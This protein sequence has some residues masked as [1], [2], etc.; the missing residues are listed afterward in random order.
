MN[1]GTAIRPAV[2]AGFVAQVAFSVWLMTNVRAEEAEL[3]PRTLPTGSPPAAPIGWVQTDL[4]VA[5]LPPADWRQIGE[6]L[7][8][9]Y[10][11]IALNTLEKWDH[12][13]PRSNDYPAHVVKNADAYLRRFV[14]TVHE[15]GAKAIFY[16]GPVQSPLVADIREKHED[17]LRVNEDGSKAKDYVNFRNPQFVNWLCEQLAWLIREY[18]VD[19]FWFDGYSPVSLHT[20]DSSTRAAFRDYSN[21][22]EIPRRGS[23]NPRDLVGRLYLQWHETYF[24][25]LA[26]R[27]RQAVRAANPSTVIYGNYSASRT[28]YEPGWPLGEYP[29][30]YANAIDLPSVEL[31]W[32]NPGDALFQQFTYAFT[33]GTSHDRGAR[34]WVQPH[35]HG[36]LGTPPAIELM[37][38]CLEGAPWGVYAEFVENSER[39]DYFKKY[40][41]EVKAREE[42]WKQSE[43]VPYLGI[44][45][46]EQ[47]RLLLGKETL[48]KYFS[49]TLGAFRALFE[50][51]LP[52]R[53]LSEYDLENNDLQGVRVILLPDVRVL[54]DRASE[55]IRRF[56][57][58][59][60]GVVATGDTGMFDHNFQQRT[61]FSLADLFM[62]DYL[63]S[64]EMTTREANLNLWIKAP[65]HP[66]LDDKKITGEEK[67]AWRSPSGPPA[68][69]GWLELV[70]SATFVRAREGAQTQLLMATNENQKAASPGMIASNHGKGRIVYL[71]AGLD[72]AMFF[73]PNSYIS[74]ILVNA[75]LWAAGEVQPPLAVDAPLILGV[76][77][78]RQPLHKRTI[79]HLLNDQSSYGRHS[80]YQKI[81]MPDNSVTGPWTVRSEIIPLHDIKVQCRIK[82]L[83]KATQ[84]PENLSLP[85]RN[86]PDGTLETVVPKVEMYS[87][88]V[89]E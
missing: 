80:I 70:A 47:T 81:R 28:W 50:A 55:V 82:G 41:T 69:R 34:V 67:T 13:G 37:L 74:A 25:E 65:K 79:V 5:H 19:G 46:S 75:T 60:G 3:P 86:L 18:G 12:V 72:Q 22:K 76:T 1:K 31:Y 52:I 20:Y 57:K 40:V 66:I 30:Y 88:I 15:A 21:G 11:V 48:L 87:M 78:R 10:Q 9:G 43:T 36:T 4:R 27:V 83:T 49:H 6:F 29:A 14:T 51:H 8:A 59:G 24:A 17:W 33:Q 73:Y 71:P 54:S 53:I 85:V 26:T 35:L 58:G 63:S 61:N 23:I 32:D 38:R 39:E 64:R 62:A 89:F 44:V 7:K 56:I 16:L 77:Y 84:Q 68:E 42:W 2:F 45:A